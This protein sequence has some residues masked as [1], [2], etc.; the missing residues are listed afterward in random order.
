[1]SPVR[2][3]GLVRTVPVG[4]VRTV[5]DYVRTVGPVRT[6]F[7]YVRTEFDYVRTA[8]PVRTVLDDVPV[9]VCLRVFRNYW[10]NIMVV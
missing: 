3:A 8:G 5:F 7:D 6:V 10:Y 9:P 4:M 2:T 1:M